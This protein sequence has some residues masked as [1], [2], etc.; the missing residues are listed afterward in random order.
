MF[1]IIDWM[2]RFCERIYYGPANDADAIEGLEYLSQPIQRSREV[3]RDFL[4]D[5]CRDREKRHRLEMELQNA[6]WILEYERR[7]AALQKKTAAQRSKAAQAGVNTERLRRLE[8][9]LAGLRR[10]LD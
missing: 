2:E 3:R 7:L 6:E 1:R 10:S 5:W 4:D 9:H 8:H